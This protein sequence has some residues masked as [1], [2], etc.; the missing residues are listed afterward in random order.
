M[1]EGLVRYTGK[2]R[3]KF[4]QRVGPHPV[5]TWCVMQ[6]HHEKWLPEKEA[7]LWQ[8]AGPW[9]VTRWREAAEPVPAAMVVA[10]PAPP[11]VHVTTALDQ[12]AEATK[13]AEGKRGLVDATFVLSDN[14]VVHA[15]DCRNSPRSPAKTFGSLE[16]AMADEDFNKVHRQCCRGH[17][18]AL[19]PA[20]PT[21]GAVAQMNILG[22]GYGHGQNS[23]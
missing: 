22:E 19:I 12:A 10:A 18:K 6:P 8:K 11:A 1:K 7:A 16:R 17:L 14:G 4:V 20:Q 23:A 9:N 15:S 2:R 13:Q 5:R 3:G 21:T